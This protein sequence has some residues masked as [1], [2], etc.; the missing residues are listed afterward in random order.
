MLE[1]SCTSNF[2]EGFLYGVC[3]VA[4]YFDLLYNLHVSTTPKSA[5][6]DAKK[7]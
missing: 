5:C 6:T 4:D 1:R 3:A 7:E 2:E